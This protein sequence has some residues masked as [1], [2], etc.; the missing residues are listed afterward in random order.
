MTTLYIMAEASCSHRCWY[1]QGNV[2]RCSCGG[3]NHGLLK[4]GGAEP[5]PRSVMTGGKNYQFTIFPA[6][7]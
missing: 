1:A 2:C 7:E 5:P 3:V 4:A 6:A